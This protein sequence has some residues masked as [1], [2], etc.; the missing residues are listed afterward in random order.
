MPKCHGLTDRR[1]DGR[2]CSI[3]ITLCCEQ[4]LKCI[5]LF[6]YPMRMNSER[7]NAGI[8]DEFKC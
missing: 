7:I 1:M 2:N 6:C 4:K 8:K 3:N 5:H